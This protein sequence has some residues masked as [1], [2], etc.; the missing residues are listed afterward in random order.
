[1]DLGAT[2]CTARAPKCLVCP[3]REVCAAAPIDPAS[4]AVAM[5]AHAKKKSPQEALPFERT[6]RFLRG[7]IIDRLRDLPP[8]A[9]ISL[10]ALQAD[11]RPIVSDD[12]VGEIADTVQ[13]LIRDGF[14]AERDGAYTLQT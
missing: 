12:R 10:A 1:M 11:L 2:I 14:V 9:S 6:Q 3:L 4:L 7:R 13:A 8:H 5:R